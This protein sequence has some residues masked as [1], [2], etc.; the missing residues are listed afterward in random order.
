MAGRR[1]LR[2][3]G[4]WPRQV[5]RGGIGSPTRKAWPGGTRTTGVGA[6]QQNRVEAARRSLQTRQ[7]AEPE[8]GVPVPAM[9]STR[10]PTVYTQPQTKGGSGAAIIVQPGGS[11][12]DKQTIAAWSPPVN[13]VSPWSWHRRTTVSSLGGGS[14]RLSRSQSQCRAAIEISGSRRHSGRDMGSPRTAVEI[15]VS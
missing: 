15:G 2:L 13:A 1:G 12:N 10:S 4:L 9:P 8:A 6:G 7:M 14:G 3:V 11:V 5:Q